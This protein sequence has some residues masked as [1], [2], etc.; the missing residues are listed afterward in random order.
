MVASCWPKLN[1]FSIEQ[2]EFL[3]IKLGLELA[4]EFELR[5]IQV[6]NDAMRVVSK[7][8][9]SQSLANKDS[10]ILEGVPKLCNV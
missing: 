8:N 3:A 5:N 6:H 2:D 4:V 10:F 9:S 1:A 7:I